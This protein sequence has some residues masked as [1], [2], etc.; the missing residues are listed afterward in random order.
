MRPALGRR[1]VRYRFDALTK[2]TT[3]ELDTRFETMT[4]GEA[5]DQISAT[6]A[7]LR[8]YGVQRGDRI[9]MLGASGVE[10][11]IFDLAL[12]VVGAIAVPP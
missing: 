1:A 5:W 2:R 10:Y 12:I 4:Y 9:C 6:A 11:T 8:S 7:A 3:A